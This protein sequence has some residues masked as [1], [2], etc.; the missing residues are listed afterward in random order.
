V[1]PRYTAAFEI[2]EWRSL[3]VRAGVIAAYH[4]RPHGRGSPTVAKAIYYAPHSLTFPHNGPWE[5]SLDNRDP[6]TVPEFADIPHAGSSIKSGRPVMTI[7]G[8]DEP[9]LRRKARELDSI[10]QWE[11]VPCR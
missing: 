11:R 8:R 9:D 3:P 1:N 7:F 2:L 4:P 10:F 6:F 5:A